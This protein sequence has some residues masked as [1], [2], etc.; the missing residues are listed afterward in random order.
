VDFLNVALAEEE[1]KE[2]KTEQEQRDFADMFGIDLKQDRFVIEHPENQKT[3]IAVCD[4]WRIQQNPSAD[5]MLLVHPDWRRQG[6]GTEL[7]KVAL[8]HAKAINA[9]AIDAYV[10]RH[11]TAAK[12]FV[13]KQ[14]FKIAGNFTAMQA[15]FERLPAKAKLAKEFIVR[16]YAELELSDEEKLSMII[17]AGRE[18]WGDLRGHKYIAEDDLAKEVVKKNYLEFFS[19]EEMFFFFEDTNYIGFDAVNISES[20]EGEK[21]GNVGPPALHV[22]WRFLRYLLLLLMLA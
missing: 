17:K 22:E 7:F 19:E 8:E 10:K 21:C 13:E 1:R 15:S 20:S 9:T 3:F 2:L 16:S 4:I 5:Q 6:I 11:Q 14:G 18:F 12:A